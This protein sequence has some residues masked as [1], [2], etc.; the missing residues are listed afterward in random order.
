MPCKNINKLI[1]ELMKEPGVSGYS[2]KP[3]KLI[4]YVVDDDYAKMF[5]AISVE[6]YEVEV[7]VIGR[8]QAL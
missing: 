6:G 1:R 5:S 2:L 4:I 8:I 3:N 7:K